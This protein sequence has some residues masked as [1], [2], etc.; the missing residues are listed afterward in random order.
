MQLGTALSREVANGDRIYLAIKASVVA[1]RFPQG[2]RIYLEPIADDLGVSTTP[3]REALNRLAAEELVI[4]APRKGFIAM[5]LS[6]DKL[7]GYHELTKLLLAHELERLSPER[8]R[9]LGEYEPIATVLYKLNRSIITNVETLAAYTGE[10]F[11]HIAALGN[12][13][14]VMRSIDRA[15]DHLLYIRTVHCRHNANA[16]RELRHLCELLLGGH[17]DELLRVLQDHHD[18]RIESLPQL[19]DSVS[20][21]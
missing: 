1:Y 21:A 7:R 8:R 11:S 16:Q 12:N 9:K 15:N 3:V 14:H 2:Q 10:I 5:T 13:A 17:C 20:A 18:T 19:L 4:K 6:A